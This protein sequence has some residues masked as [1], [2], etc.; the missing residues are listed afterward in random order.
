MMDLLRGRAHVAG[1]RPLDRVALQRAVR[2]WGLPGALGGVLLAAAALLGAALT[3]ALKQQAQDTEQAA[4]A[5]RRA[6]AAQATR[7]QA[8]ASTSDAPERF[9]AAFPDAA[10]R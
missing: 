5:A 2:R 10:Q 3:P 1:W 4:H 9:V 6:A 7:V 8:V